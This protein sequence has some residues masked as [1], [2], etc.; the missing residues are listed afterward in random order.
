MGCTELF[1]TESLFLC[2]VVSAGWVIWGI[3]DAYQTLTTNNIPVLS[4]LVGFC[5]YIIF[6]ISFQLFS[7]DSL[8][9]LCQPFLLDHFLLY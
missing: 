8:Q 6:V 5:D 2:D 1:C 3:A 4:T 7:L 9:C